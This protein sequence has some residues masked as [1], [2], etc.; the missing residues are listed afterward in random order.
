MHYDCSKLDQWNIIFDHA[1]RQGVFL[2]FKMQENELDDKPHRP[3]KRKQGEVPTAL[4]GGELGPETQTLLPGTG[5]P[6][7]SSSSLELEPRRGEYAIDTRTNR[8]GKVYLP[9]CDPY[10][11]HIVVHT[12]PGQQEKVYTALLGKNSAFHRREFAKTV[13]IKLMRGP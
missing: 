1:Q 2:H 8:H 13:G 11:H 5:R 9:S 4:D 6:F 7:R 12:F 3:R 10:K